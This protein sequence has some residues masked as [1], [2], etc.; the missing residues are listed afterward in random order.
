[1]ESYLRKSAV[2]KAGDKEMSVSR[3]SSPQPV[4]RSQSIDVSTREVREVREIKPDRKVAYQCDVA[5]IKKSIET[6]QNTVQLQQSD[7]LSKIVEIQNLLASMKQ[8]AEQTKTE[9]LKQ[10]FDTFINSYNDN[11]KAHSETIMSLDKEL[12]CMHER[13]VVVEDVL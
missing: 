5:D 9:R 4:S 1:M 7:T 6:L 13:M 8:D 11:E 10:K 3:A 12:K 2:L